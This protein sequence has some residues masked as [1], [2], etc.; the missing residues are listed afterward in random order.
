MNEIEIEYCEPCGLLPA[1]EKTGHALLTTHAD[2]I[3]GL[4]FTPGHGGV[5]RVDVDGETVFDKASD[6]DFDVD[7]IVARVGAR[8]SPPTIQL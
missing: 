6:E 4:R 8:L 7:V 2:R 1:A 3:H 5:F